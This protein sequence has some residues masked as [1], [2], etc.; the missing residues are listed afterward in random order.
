MSNENIPNVENG[1]NPNIQNSDKDKDIQIQ[2]TG[3]L[4]QS[5]KSDTEMVVFSF[6]ILML[7]ITAIVIIP[8]EGTTQAPVYLKGKLKV[9]T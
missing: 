9:R 6:Q 7:E 4:K 3:T 2:L 8:A 1:S 5:N